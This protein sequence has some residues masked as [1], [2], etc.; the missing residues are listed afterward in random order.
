MQKNIV[1]TAYI[2]SISIEYIDLFI[3]LNSE[4]K[5]YLQR[6]TPNVRSI[7]NIFFVFPSIFSVFQQQIAIL[8]QDILEIH[9]NTFFL[10]T[11]FGRYTL[12][13]HVFAT[14][15][16]IFI[17]FFLTAKVNTEHLQSFVLKMS[18]IS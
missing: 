9:R 3:H 12:Y 7:S 8:S 10:A 18:L 15:V 17:S 16:L 5:K 4:Q 2:W 6:N 1:N 13:I 11:V 14:L